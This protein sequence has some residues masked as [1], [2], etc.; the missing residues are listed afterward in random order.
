MGVRAGVLVE[1]ESFADR[2]GWVVDQQFM[3]QMGSPYLLAHGLGTPVKDAV[4]QVRMA[5]GDY[6]VW[7][8]TRDW[9]R[10][11]ADVGPGEFRVLVNGGEIGK[12]GTGGSGEWEWTEGPKVSVARSPVEVRL[13][14]LTGFEGRVDAIFFAVGDERPPE[15][16]VARKRL[17]GLGAPSEEQADLIVV[18]GGLA[19]VCAAVTAA[20]E[21]L[22]VVLV[23]DRPVFGGNA[24]SEVRVAVLG[25][26]GKGPFPHNGDV[27]KEVLS[28]VDRTQRPAWGDKWKFDDARMGAWLA[29]QKG[30]RLFPSTRVTSV[31]KNDRG[32]I[33][34]VIGRNVLTGAETRFAAK[35]FVDSTGDGA[36]AVAAGAEW[37]WRP[38]TRAETGESLAPDGRRKGGDYGSSLYWFAQDVKEERA[39]PRCPWA[40]SVDKPTDALLGENEEKWL[41][42]GGWNW[43]TGFWE[44]NVTNGEKIRDRLFR[45][46][47]G[48]WDFTKNKRP[49]RERFA[50]SEIYW[51][52]Y[53]LG[54]RAARRVIGDHILTERDLVER[55]AYPDGVVTTDWYID[56]HFPQPTV[57]KKFGRD[58][59]RSTAYDAWRAEDKVDPKLYVG[60]KID[61]KPYE[62]PFR[63]LYSKTVPN[64]LLA[65]KDISATHV[66][67]GSHRVMNTGGAMGTVVARAAA[68]CVRDGVLPRALSSGEGLD[69]LKARLSSPV[70]AAPAR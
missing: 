8:R 58:V 25:G 10:P 57:E 62:I 9:C 21:G 20:R 51:M 26:I 49:D 17:L 4:T 42:S 34:A 52:G 37:R 30:L 41:P 16:W 11:M 36:V 53:V 46:V 1:A 48:T 3:D 69:K 13:S 47:Y 19:G 7:V 50:K 39:F 6:R 38:E 23:Q 65:G 40:L 18:G 70:P 64:L 56:L 68:I 5:C 2:G 31:E 14:D 32:E 29:A 67:M 27:L 66:A 59:F 22:S 54:K 12:F 15:T 55:V 45:A 61:I 24:S 44:D 43:E 60:G 63:C 35:L 33:A 28:F